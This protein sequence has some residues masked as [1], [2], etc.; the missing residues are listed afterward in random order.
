MTEPRKRRVAL[1]NDKDQVIGYADIDMESLEAGLRIADVPVAVDPTPILEALAKAR[2]E[3]LDF[4]A[5][6]E[7]RWEA[8]MRAIKMWRNEDPEPRE[9]IWPNHTDLC[10][11]LLEERERWLANGLVDELQSLTNEELERVRDAA[12]QELEDRKD[13][14]EDAQRGR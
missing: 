14:W 13:T 6:F 3:I 8:D 12:Q 2:K 7:L 1:K 4:E 9:L 11:G 5:S 10:V